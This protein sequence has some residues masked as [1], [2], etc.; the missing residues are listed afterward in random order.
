[1]SVRK[2]HNTG[3]NH[4]RNVTEYYQQIG[5]EKA[6]SVIDSITNSYAAEG[7]PN[8][9]LQQPGAGPGFPP[10]GFPGNFYAVL[11]KDV[12]DKE[13]ECLHHLSVLLRAK[14]AWCRLAEEACHSLHLVPMVGPQLTCHSLLLRAFLRTF[15]HNSLLVASTQTCSQD[16]TA[17][18]AILAQAQAPKD[19][20]EATVLDHHLVL[21]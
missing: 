19:L 8:P 10:M 13:Q 9:M 7:Q 3:R 12:T 16:N 14:L 5:H 18:Q 4:L 15:H 6:Q 17:H 20:P 2:S 1:M 21:A 11:L